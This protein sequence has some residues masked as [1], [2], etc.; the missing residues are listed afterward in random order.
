MFTIDGVMRCVWQWARNCIYSWS[1]WINLLR[2]VF[3]LWLL[4]ARVAKTKFIQTGGARCWA[5][6]PLAGTFTKAAAKWERNI[7]VM[8]I[9]SPEMEALAQIKSVKSG[10]LN[11]WEVSRYKENKTWSTLIPKVTATGKK[12][13][14]Y[15]SATINLVSKA[16]VEGAFLKK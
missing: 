12:L 8:A 16:K 5:L 10:T 15:I 7:F 9:W 4:P 6:E 1:G 3:P 2:S 14:Y 11:N 13:K